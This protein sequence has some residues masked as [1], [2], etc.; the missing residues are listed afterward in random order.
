MVTKPLLMNS[1]L[2]LADSRPAD[3]GTGTANLGGGGG[4]RGRRRSYQEQP[5]SD[6][7]VT[8]FVDVMMVLLIIFM[9]AAPLSVVGIPVDLPKTSAP[10]LPG[11]EE[12][13][14]TVTITVDGR[15]MI[16]ETETPQ[17][18]LVQKLQAIGAERDSN[19]IFLRADGR[20]D[21]NRVAV[22][23]SLLNAAGFSDIGLVTDI[24]GPAQNDTEG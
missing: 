4:R 14:L 15:V 5:I 23:M 12:E 20:N 17:E 7:N 9:V 10:T 18:L 1:R 2:F 3:M 21:W 19:K 16:Q 13:P 24:A 6:I 8:P 22:I 11:D